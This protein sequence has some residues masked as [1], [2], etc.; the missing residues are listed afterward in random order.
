[1]FKL[2]KGFFEMNMRV[3]VLANGCAGAKRK[4]KCNISAG[5]N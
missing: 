3:V 1:M 2:Y 4:T 5:G